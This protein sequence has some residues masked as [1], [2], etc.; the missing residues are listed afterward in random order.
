M[1]DITRPPPPKG[2]HRPPCV[3]GDGKHYGVFYVPDGPITCVGC[4]ETNG[5]AVD[6]RQVREPGRALDPLTDEE[7]ALA[8]CPACRAGSQDPVALRTAELRA[9]RVLRG[10]AS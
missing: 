10:K 1:S 4:G 6:R 5:V 3:E 7:A 8:A 9:R 2:R